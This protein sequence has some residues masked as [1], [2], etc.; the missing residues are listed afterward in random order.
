M[1]RI[2]YSITEEAQAMA[3]RAGEPAAAV[4]EYELPQELVA[5]ALDAGATVD[6]DGNV[7][8][9]IGV[10]GDERAVMPARLW[11]VLPIRPRDAV[12][13]LGL[14]DAAREARAVVAAKKAAEVAA[15]EAA[16]TAKRAER[17]RVYDEAAAAYLA[18]GS[19]EPSARVTGAWMGV[20]T[21]ARVPI[22]RARRD[23][24]AQDARK[25]ADAERL[26]P[27]R[28]YARTVPAEADGYAVEHA[29][30]RHAIGV[31]LDAIG[32][33]GLCEVYRDHGER[34]APS[35][36]AL[37]LRDQVLAV[38]DGVRSELPTWLTIEVGRVSRIEQPCGDACREEDGETQHAPGCEDP[39]TAIPVTITVAAVGL[40]R[41]VAVLAE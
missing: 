38:V 25:R 15:E 37:A 2:I 16:K 21:D 19:D 3:A 8:L 41:E 6:A 9:A 28:A 17:Q 40:T 24:V 18:G 5:R 23:A 35:P 27:L 11:Q 22:E 1:N 10:Y 7:T 14:W 31:V 26:A 30:A 29:A 32:R 36:E 13:A 12:H 33:R 20:Q 34:A 39:V 4:Q